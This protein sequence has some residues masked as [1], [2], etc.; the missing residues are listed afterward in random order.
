MADLANSTDPDLM[1]MQNSRVIGPRRFPWRFKRN[2][3]REGNGWE[4]GMAYRQS[5]EG[6]AW[7]CEG[8]EIRD[9]RDTESV[10]R[11][12]RREAMHG[13]VTGNVRE[14]GLCKT[15]RLYPATTHSVY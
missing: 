11:C 12:S 5:P 3:G 2:T 9:A 14:V 10:L 8:R 15:C 7:N 13:T 6:N 1:G 4:D